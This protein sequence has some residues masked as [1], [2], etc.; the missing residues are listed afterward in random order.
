[1]ETLIPS[2][3]GADLLVLR[4]LS[5]FLIVLGLVGVVSMFFN[6]RRVQRRLLGLLFACM[7][8]GGLVLGWKTDQLLVADRD[9]TP[10]QQAALS[11][12]I[13]QFP[14][15]KF[16]VHTLRNDSEAKSL[17]LKIADAIKAGSGAM[18]QVMD[19]LP[20]VAPGVIFVFAPKDIDLRR[21]FS[22]V[23]GTQL[24]AARI[25]V[26]TDEAVQ[27]EQAVRIVVGRKP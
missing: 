19:G 23:V 9:L 17:A 3:S 13:S 24:A 20:D 1:M 6:G 12:A 5:K 15:V 16:E 4:S 11:K 8:V 10:A 14:G 22:D 27:P 21:S 2:L 26:I 25:A 7:A 18:P